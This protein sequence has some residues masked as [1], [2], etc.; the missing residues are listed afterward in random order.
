MKI[1]NWHPR[2]LYCDKALLAVAC[3]ISFVLTSCS[4]APKSSLG[5]ILPGAKD[6]A[7]I[8]VQGSDT[9]ES[10]MHKWANDYMASKPGLQ[11]AVK[12]GDTGI[13]ID[14]LLTGKIDLAA[15]SREITEEEHKAAHS[16]GVHLKRLMVARDAIAVVV[17]P[18]NT[19]VEID[20]VDLAK[21]YLGEIV[22]WKQLRKDLAAEPIRAFGR[23][24]TSGTSDYFQEHVLSSKP[25]APVVKV[26]P[27]SE[28]LIGAVMGNRL[29]IGFV[30]MAQAARATDKVKVLKL[31][32]TE[33]SPESAQGGVLSGS[34][35]PLSRPLYVYYNQANE[36]R[37]GKFVSFCLAE[38]GQKSVKAMGFMPAH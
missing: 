2:F 10:L 7:S 26:M 27:S 9:M 11:I 28:A 37:V 32:L 24:S 8:V 15:A 14:D 12:D 18:Q 35:Y 13:G 30:G 1:I 38:D 31:K 29:A 3:G 34:D 4:S 17:N 33:K 25:Y 36:E 23:E 21:I 6:G 5:Q 20:L 19:I 22:T 16:K